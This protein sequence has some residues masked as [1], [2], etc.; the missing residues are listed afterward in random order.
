MAISI[1]PA[2]MLD[3][4]R[5]I[6]AQIE[7]EKAIDRERLHFAKSLQAF[8]E[9]LDREQERAYLG[10]LA[11]PEAIDAVINA[12]GSWG[13]DLA[14]RAQ[15]QW[16][17]DELTAK[18]GMLRNMARL[19]MLD[20]TQVK[21]LDDLEPALAVRKSAAAWGDRKPQD[22][23]EG[24]PA[25]V[26]LVSSDGVTF[27][28]QVGNV[29]TSPSNLRQQ[30]IRHLTKN[31]TEVTDDMKAEILRHTN[32]VCKSEVLSTEVFGVRIEVV[33]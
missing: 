28:T 29:V 9:R 22:P 2:K 24:R 14:P 12:L 10:E 33:A 1:N 7:S 8:A 30:I 21:E 32:R 26:K 20:K 5:T 13:D 25:R 18:V 6:A 11:A 31:G 23:I 17:R 27:S 3:E 15:A 16:R 4:L 19:D